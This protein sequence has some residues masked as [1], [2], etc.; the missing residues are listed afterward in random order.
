MHHIIAPSAPLHVPDRS[1]RQFDRLLVDGV[2]CEAELR[3]EYDDQATGK[4]G[5]FWIEELRTIQVAAFDLNEYAEARRG[6]TTDEWIALLI[7]T[8]GRSLS[9]WRSGAR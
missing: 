2:W 8:I 1:V 9:V 7:R 4:R 6:F 3:H 5:P